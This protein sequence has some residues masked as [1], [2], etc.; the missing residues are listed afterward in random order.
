MD[1]A[2]LTQLA[3]QATNILIPALSALSIAGRPAV[4]KGKEVLVD[5]IY[6]KAF[7]KL[8]SESGKRA[9]AL[10]EKINPKMSASLKKALSKVLRNS[11]DPKAEEELQQEILNL[12][13]ENPG[14][15]KEI[16]PIVINSNVENIDQFALGNYN[17]FFNFKTPSGDELI[18]IIEY[19]DQKRKEAANQEILDRY[20]PS[21]LPYYPE[22]LKLFVTENRSEELKKALTYLENHRILLLSGVGGVGKSTLARAL[23][24]LRPVNV[25]EPF[26]FDF[27]QNQSAKLGDILEKLAS[28]L[29]APEIAAFK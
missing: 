23:M 3:Q 20:N 7:E 27:N 26:W 22:K 11:Q 16:K 13:M 12:L 4:D 29:K 5:L 1:P 2:T 19:L 28:Y 6:E 21:T 10:L 17:N 18:K 9:Q 15:A 8:G 24:D 25:P 14:L